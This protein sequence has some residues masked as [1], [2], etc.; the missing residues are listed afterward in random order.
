[1][2]ECCTVP[3]ALL[4]CMPCYNEAG[5]TF[6]RS[7]AVIRTCSIETLQACSVAMPLV[8]RSIAGLTSHLSRA[9][10]I[11]REKKYHAHSRHTC[12]A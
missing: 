6:E 10:Y 12:R 5:V 11:A 2:F 3:L 9:V 1:M 7:T 4:H 8:Q